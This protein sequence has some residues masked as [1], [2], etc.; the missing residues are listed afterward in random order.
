[1]IGYDE[2]LYQAVMWIS[3]GIYPQF[4][5]MGEKKA[6]EAVDFCSEWSEHLPLFLHKGND[7]DQREIPGF[8]VRSSVYGMAVMSAF[9]VWVQKKAGNELPT[10]PLLEAC[11]T[12]Y[13][14]W[15]LRTKE[16]KECPQK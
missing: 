12:G 1:M 6:R 16:V 7:F 13:N 14:L 2:A 10:S 15:K 4:E 3:V 11:E 9:V 8:G 5:A